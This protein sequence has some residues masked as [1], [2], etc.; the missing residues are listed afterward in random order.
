MTIGTIAITVGIILLIL[1]KILFKNKIFHGINHV[2][3]LRKTLI[4]IQPG[5]FFRQI[6]I[7]QMMID[8][9]S[10]FFSKTLSL[11]NFLSFCGGV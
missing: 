2:N 9:E 3:F 8:I 4:L 10:Y 5:L 7:K 1:L 11:K 6:F